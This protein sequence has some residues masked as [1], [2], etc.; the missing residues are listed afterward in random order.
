[1]IIPKRILGRIMV[2]TRCCKLAQTRG[3]PDQI[4][5]QLVTMRGDEDDREASDH[6]GVGDDDAN[7]GIVT[8]DRVGVRRFNGLC[9]VA[10]FQ[11]T[12]HG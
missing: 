5:D 8:D 1:V 4:V 9:T 6:P 2:N 11:L 3:Q 7:P 10:P 12:L